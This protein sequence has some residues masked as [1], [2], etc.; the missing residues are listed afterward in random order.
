MFKFGFKFGFVFVF[1]SWLFDEYIVVDII[2][3]AGIGCNGGKLLIMLELMLE[4]DSFK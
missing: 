2:V 3:D 1:L 4:F